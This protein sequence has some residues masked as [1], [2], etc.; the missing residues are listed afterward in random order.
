ME[1]LF[2]TLSRLAGVVR[3]GQDAAAV[4]I[5]PVVVAVS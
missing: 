4:P 5:S 2:W 1:L 3:Q